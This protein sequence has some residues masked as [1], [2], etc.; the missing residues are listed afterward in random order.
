ML[1]LR[2]KLHKRWWTRSTVA[3]SSRKSREQMAWVSF[4][5]TLTDLVPS[6]HLWKRT[7]SPITVCMIGERKLF[8]HESFEKIYKLSFCSIYTCNFTMLIYNI[9]IYTHT[10]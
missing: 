2:L 6:E 5:P 7:N 9:Y 10:L 8:F 4:D 1:L 3:W